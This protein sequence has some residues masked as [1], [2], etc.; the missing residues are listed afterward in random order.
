APALAGLTVRAFR[1]S[2]DGRRMA[3]V[4][5][6][7][8]EGTPKG[9]LGLVEVRHGADGRLSLDGWRPVP[10]VLGNAPLAG[11]SDVVWEGPSTLA[12][13]GSSQGSEVNA[14]FRVRLDGIET[15][16]EIGRP[17]GDRLLTMVA[18]RPGGGGLV[19]LDDSGAAHQWLDSH[20]WQLLASG[21]EALA[22]PG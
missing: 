15:A 21:I 4:A 9:Q 12:V 3:V 10:A 2:P 17:S 5:D 6:G 20:E 11:M 8:G 18:A 1:L 13:L 19:V 7:T 16:E 22:Y 14:L